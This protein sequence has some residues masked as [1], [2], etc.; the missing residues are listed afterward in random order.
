[1]PFQSHNR[2]H[3]NRP[4]WLL[5]IACY[6]CLGGSAFAV[7]NNEILQVF[8]DSDAPTAGGFSFTTTTDTDLSGSNW[9]FGV[10]ES[11]VYHAALK[12]QQTGGVAN[13]DWE[14]RI[15]EGG[16]IYSLRS[17]FGEIVPPQSLGRH[18]VDEVFQSIS[19]DTSPRA[20]GDQAAFYHCLLY[21]S[22]SPRDATLSRMPS[23][24]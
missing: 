5:A 4:L 15:G 3:R 6:L 7:Q 16:Q 14:I 9:G 13:R 2:R 21:T 10:D 22:P 23:S 12:H 18:F 11:T 17:E 19:V 24:A 20:N 1:M 8:S